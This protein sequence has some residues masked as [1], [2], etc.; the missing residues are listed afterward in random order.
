MSI[1][2]EKLQQWPRPFRMGLGCVKV[3]G[4]KNDGTDLS[5]ERIWGNDNF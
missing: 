5:S 1:A 4:K 2:R 3:D